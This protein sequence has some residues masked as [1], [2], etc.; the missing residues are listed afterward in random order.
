[1]FTERRDEDDRMIQVPCPWCEEPARVVGPDLVCDSCRVVVELVDDRR[2][3][4]VAA[5]A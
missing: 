1:M 5:A 2:P 4:E 3:V